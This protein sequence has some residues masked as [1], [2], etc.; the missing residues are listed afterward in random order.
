[1]AST[2]RTAPVA[3]KKVMTQPINHIYKLLQSKARVVVWL[4]ENKRQRM[5]GTLVGF[6][7]FM[8]LVLEDA[9]EVDLKKKT[10]T[11]LGKLMLK[12]DAVTLIQEEGEAN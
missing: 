11:P 9:A 10:R 2:S 12:G 3:A 8:N 6:D 7:E 1:M 4:H 5:E